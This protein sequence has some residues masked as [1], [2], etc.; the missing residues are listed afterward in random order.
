MDFGISGKTALVLGASSGLGRAMAV[1][2]A[3]EGVN[4]AVGARSERGLGETCGMIN[5]AGAQALP[6][7][8]DLADLSI[9]D[10]R[11]S[12][13]ERELGPV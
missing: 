6:L 4:V 9:I 10:E 5:A 1:G 3:Q 2:L 13:V 11:V 8:W 7:V 12:Q